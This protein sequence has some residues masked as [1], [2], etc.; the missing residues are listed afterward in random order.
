[1]HK[2]LRQP[3]ESSPPAEPEPRES[4]EEPKVESPW[5]WKL[6]ESDVKPVEAWEKLKTCNKNITF[7]GMF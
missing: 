4:L 6:M 3:Q 5:V 2:M 1:M 7:D